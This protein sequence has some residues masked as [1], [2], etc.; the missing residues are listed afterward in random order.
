[1][2]DIIMVDVIEHHL[3]EMLDF[4]NTALEAAG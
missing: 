2:N 3:P 1:M 4:A